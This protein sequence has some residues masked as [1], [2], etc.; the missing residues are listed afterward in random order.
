[1]HGIERQD[2]ELVDRVYK[3]GLAK[4]KQISSPSCIESIVQSVESKKL[5]Q[6]SWKASKI[7]PKLLNEKECFWQVKLYRNCDSS[8]M[9]GSS[10]TWLELIL[11]AYP[12]KIDARTPQWMEESNFVETARLMSWLDMP[13][14]C[15]WK[16]KLSGACWASV[17]I[18]RSNICAGV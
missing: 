12:A 13:A 5:I 11:V 18:E 2:G 15:D 17:V 8:W 10:R 1:M 3:W 7:L 9:G 16:P 4:Y 6:Y 14:A